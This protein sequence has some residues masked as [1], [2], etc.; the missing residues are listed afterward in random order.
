MSNRPPKIPSYRL[1]KPTGQAVV[2]L[3]GHDHY[4]GK[5]NTE[6]SHEAYC[7][8]IGEWLA[9]GRRRTPEPPQSATMI[10]L[11][12]N[13][14]ILAHRHYA[15]RHY[16]GPDGRPTRGLDN[17]RAALR[18]LRRVYGGAVGVDGEAGQRGEREGCMRGQGRGAGDMNCTTA[19][20][21]LV[22]RTGGRGFCRAG[23]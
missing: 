7:R 11:S 13:D 17:L 14:L 15:E 10:R 23:A 2:R 19:F 18:P 6:A 9:T 22:V 8:L 3:N 12:V 20:S 1:H 4:L 16:Q 21:R 5:H